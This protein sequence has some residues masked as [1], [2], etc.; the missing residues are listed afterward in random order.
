MKF[1]KRLHVNI[2]TFLIV[3]AALGVV[4]RAVNI[5]TFRDTGAS[6]IMSAKAEDHAPPPH[7]APGAP[8]KD[9]VQ[10]SVDETVK[11]LGDDTPAASDVKDAAKPAEKAAGDMPL[12]TSDEQRA[13]SA[14][15]IEVLQSL[16]KRRDDLEKRE[17]KLAAREALLTASEEEVDR[18]VAE[19]TKLKGDIE[20]LL[21]Q[22]QDMEDGRINSLVKI[23]ENMK[24]KEAATIFNTLDMDVLLSVIGRMKEAKSSPVLAAMDPDKARIVTIKLAEQRKLPGATAPKKAPAAPAT[25]PAE[26]ATP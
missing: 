16:A 5:V 22:Q 25:P 15:E 18:K 9:D 23:Y 4:M 14:Q 13:F 24:P 7:D 3:A 21:G 20:K 10:K 11:Q 8:T 19:L 17:Q 1:L 6:A 12:N 26:P 2:F